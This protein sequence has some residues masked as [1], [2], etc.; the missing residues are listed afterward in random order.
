[1]FGF[2][3]SYQERVDIS[4]DFILFRSFRLTYEKDLSNYHHNFKLKGDGPFSVEIGC[5]KVWF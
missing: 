4:F 3:E 2:H 1:M 5:Q